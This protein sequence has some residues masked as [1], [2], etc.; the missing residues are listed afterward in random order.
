[1]LDDDDI[2]VPSIG[3]MNSSREDLAGDSELTVEERV[4]KMIEEKDQRAM[5]AWTMMPRLFD[6]WG[7][8]YT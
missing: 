4:E 7:M 8:S 5:E 6:I 3:G 2:P 1:M